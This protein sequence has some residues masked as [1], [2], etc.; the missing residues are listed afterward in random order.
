[1]PSKHSSS[2]TIESAVSKTLF[3]NVQDI[4]HDKSSRCNQHPYGPLRSYSGPQVV[5]DTDSSSFS[6]KN[7]RNTRQSLLQTASV[8]RRAQ[9]KESNIETNR[10][11]PATYGL[12]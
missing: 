3:C 11:I 8:M 2:A 7:E 6:I 4:Q 12:T 1:M 9:I 5:A 10:R